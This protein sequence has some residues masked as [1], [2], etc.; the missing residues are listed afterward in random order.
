[1]NSSTLSQRVPIGSRASKTCSIT[2]DESITLYNSPYIRLDVPLA[3][4]GSI[5][6]EYVGN[7]TVDVDA[8]GSAVQRIR[9]S[10]RTSA[11]MS[12][13]LLLA[14]ASSAFCSAA[15]TLALLTLLSSSNVPTSNLGFFR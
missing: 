9:K 15:S 10:S 8:K 1:M 12:V 13:P 3:Y 7:S 14:A 5:M 4:I 2:S 6:S 11:V